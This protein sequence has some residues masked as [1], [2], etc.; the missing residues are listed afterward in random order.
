[1]PM[2]VLGVYSEPPPPE[3]LGVSSTRVD[4]GRAA[5][6]ANWITSRLNEAAQVTQLLPGWPK[7]AEVP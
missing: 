5:R 1:M 7:P 2:Q 6:A 4:A 3:M